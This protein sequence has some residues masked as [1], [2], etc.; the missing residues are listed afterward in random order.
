MKKVFICSAFSGKNIKENIKIAKGLC[1]RFV[2]DG[3]IPFA[4]HL[5]FTQFL[6]DE[7]TEEREL[8]LECSLEW[9]EICD[10]MY[11]F[12]ELTAGM[13]KEIEW[14]EE[15]KLKNGYD[16]HHVPT[17]YVENWIK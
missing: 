10:V 13:K 3:D 15:H 11:I 12:G 1:R 4:P 2:Q 6:D 14:W 5:Y 7:N 16:Y 17:D 8:G 9:L